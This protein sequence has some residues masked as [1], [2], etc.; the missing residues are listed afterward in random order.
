MPVPARCGIRWHVSA[1]WETSWSPD[2]NGMTFQNEHL[3]LQKTTSKQFY[4]TFFLLHDYL[5]FPLFVFVHQI[6]LSFH[7][8]RTTVLE[9]IKTV[10]YT[11][12]MA[13]KDRKSVV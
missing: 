13:I 5:F 12:V 9:S 3:R 8:V 6:S 4:R 10:S 2:K 11:P 7:V 1:R